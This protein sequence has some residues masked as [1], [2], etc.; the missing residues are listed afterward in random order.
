M[1]CSAP[2][3]AYLRCVTTW[4][5][6]FIFTGA[7]YPTGALVA[8]YRQALL[9]A[10]VA[11]VTIVLADHASIR[12]EDLP[13]VRV[14]YLP[15]ARARKS[16]AGMLRYGPALLR[17]GWRL[18]KAMR[19]AGCLRLQVN[20]YHYLEG[21]VARLLGFR[22]R[23]VT[24]VRIAPASYGPAVSATWLCIAHAVSQEIVAVSRHIHAALPAA[25]SARVIYDPAPDWPTIERSRASGKLVFIGNY[26]EG[27]GQDLAIA[28]FSRIANAFPDAELIMHGSDMG[29]EK[30]RRYRDRLS[31]SAAKVPAGE[32][33]HVR[34][35][36]PDPG[37][38]LDDALAA[39][40]LSRS[41]SFSLTVQEASARG[42]AVIA[43]RSGGPAE[44]VEHGE[45]GWLVPV[46]D[47]DAIAQAMAQALSNRQA[48]LEMGSRGARLVRERFGADAFRRQVAELFALSSP[49]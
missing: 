30:N 8:A 16:V 49:D 4:P 21:A 19:D 7:H 32:R 17:A 10:D 2:K 38:V 40:N 24:W 48:T 37:A 46:D 13:G 9:L 42:V 6:L 43:T 1:L 29:L 22:G 44:I 12:P 28:A 23:I 3:S 41:E 31:R 25:L 20:D 15:L 5:A 11:D 35:F 47:V 18:R 45:T 34:D 27:K 26:I 39:L 36:A 14:A 33:I